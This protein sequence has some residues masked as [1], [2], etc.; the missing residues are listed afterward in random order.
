MANHLAFHW[1]FLSIL[2]FQGL[3]KHHTTLPIYKWVLKWMN[4]EKVF[5]FLG[6]A[7]TQ[8]LWAVTDSIHLLPV[9]Q[10]Q[11][12]QNNHDHKHKEIYNIF[13]NQINSPKYIV[14]SINIRAICGA[15]SS[16]GRSTIKFVGV[17]NMRKTVTEAP[18]S[19]LSRNG[20]PGPASWLQIRQPIIPK[21]FIPHHI[22]HAL[23]YHTY[24]ISIRP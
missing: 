10:S 4:S 13:V 16:Y 19:V 11:H 2:S 9:S 6:V 24:T 18:V 22:H 7:L 21:L 23:I 5:V 1:L 12:W 17:D 8:W 20:N 14:C 15:S 3:L